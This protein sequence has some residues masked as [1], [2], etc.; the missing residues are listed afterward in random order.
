MP[1][2]IP[3][4]AGWSASSRAEISASF[5]KAASGSAPERS[6]RHQAGQPN[7]SAPR[8]AGPPAPA[9]PP[10][11]AP[12]R[13]PPASSSRLT[14]MKHSSGPRPVRV[15][16]RGHGPGQG[17]C[18]L[19]PVHGM[20]GVGVPHH[21][22]GLVALQLADKMPAQ[23]QVSQLGRLVRASWSRFS[24]TSVTPRAASRRTSSRRV[25]LGDDDQL[26]R[27][28]LPPGGS[29]GGVDPVA[30]TAARLVRAARGGRPRRRPRLVM[31]RE[32]HRVGR[33]HTSPANRPVAGCRGRRTGFVFEGAAAGVLHGDALGLQ[34]AAAPAGRS[35]P[36]S[37]PAMLWH[38]V[39][40]TAAATS[41]RMPSGH[42]V[43][44][45]ADGRS[46]PGAGCSGSKLAQHRATAAGTTPA[47]TPGPARM[48]HA[49]GPA[50]RPAAV[51]G[52]QHHGD[53]VGHHDGQRRAGGNHGVG[54]RGR[55]PSAAST[56][57]AASPIMATALP[58]TWFMNWKLRG[59]RGRRPVRVPC[60][61][62]ALQPDRR[63]TWR[64]RF[65]AP[66]SVNATQTPGRTSARHE[67]N[68]NTA[69]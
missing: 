4:A 41:A 51:P 21:G 3:E 14:W 46:D 44:A 29:C 42:L 45:P 62:A 5:A 50:S 69:K 1:A 30:W 23:C 11:L 18:Q 66:A 10:R 59:R 61:G 9:R 36:G 35:R 24:P 53:A 39:A 48:G 26:R 65:P 19:R 6:H 27:V 34:L 63:P 58:C 40:G 13:W 38:Q 7:A 16:L 22:L 15:L 43:A 37:A 57:P 67:N 64:A 31:V 68:Q 49:P 12:P 60:A 20:D 2:E 55:R 47:A 56:A 28:A 8:R 17:G 54:G 52:P 25:E 32:V 33:V